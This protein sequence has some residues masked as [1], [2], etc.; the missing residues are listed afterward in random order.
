M[1][2]HRQHII[3]LDLTVVHIT[4]VWKFNPV[5]VMWNASNEGYILT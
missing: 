2:F 1:S 5:F 4:Y 3:L